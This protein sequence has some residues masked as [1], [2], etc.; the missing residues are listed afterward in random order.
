MRLRDFPYVS[1]RFACRDCP[2]R[3][4]YRLAVLA[5][6]FGADADLD[7]VLAEI[8]SSCRQRQKP[9]RDYWCQAYCVDLQGGAA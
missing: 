5:E 8:S 6:Q 3:G 1:V 9:T 2:R 7:D 4:R